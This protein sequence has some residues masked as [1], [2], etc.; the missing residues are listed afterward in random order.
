MHASVVPWL[1][2]TARVALGA[3][4][5]VLTAL[6]GGVAILRHSQ[7][8]GAVAVVQTALRGEWRRAVRWRRFVRRR[9][10]VRWRR[11]VALTAA[12]PTGHAAP[13]TCM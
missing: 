5:V 12:R 8:L 9:R 1:A 7:L 10:A 11:F 2:A 3:V 13:L 6:G 4:A